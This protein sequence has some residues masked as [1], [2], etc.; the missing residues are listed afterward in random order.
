MVDKMFDDCYLIGGGAFESKMMKYVIV[1]KIKKNMRM[2][3]IFSV[4][5]SMSKIV[6][7]CLI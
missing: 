5:F 2:L 4:Y 7:C 3:F 1:Y 6:M